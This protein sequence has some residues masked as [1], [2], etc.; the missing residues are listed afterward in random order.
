[1]DSSNYSV[2]IPYEDL[3]SLLHSA[4]R[5]PDLER[6][7]LRKEAE[8]DALRSQFSELMIKFGELRSFVVD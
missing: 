2:L 5:V 3:M 1:M 4:Q 7:L 6:R 8:I